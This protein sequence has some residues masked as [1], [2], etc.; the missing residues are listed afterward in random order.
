V[1]IDFSQDLISSLIGTTAEDLEVRPKA[2]YTST[3]T[4]TLDDVQHE[5]ARK[6]LGDALI[7]TR[8]HTMDLEAAVIVHYF[9]FPPSLFSGRP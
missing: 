1:H 8:S 2:R 5:E 3:T 7:A 9:F 6:H 4:T